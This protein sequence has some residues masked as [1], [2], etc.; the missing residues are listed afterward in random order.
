MWGQKM[1]KDDQENKPVKKE[2]NLPVRRE[3]G[4]AN[5]DLLYG[6]LKKLQY[7]PLLTPEEE[8]DLTR[9]YQ[10][11]KDP[12]IG[13]HL[14]TS[15]LRLVVKI[16][17]EYSTYTSNILDLIQ[18]GNVGLIQAVKHF[19]PF[20]GVRL[21]HYAQYWIRS[22]IIY[23]LL[24][25]HRLVKVGTT[26]AQRKIFFNLRKEQARLLSMGFKPTTKLI[27][28]GLNVPEHTVSEM[29]Q[30][31]DSPDV[32]MDAPRSDDNDTS[33]AGIMP[34]AS[35]TPEQE[36]SENE[37]MDRFREKMDEFGQGLTTYRDRFIWE[38]RLTSDDPVTL[39]TIGEDFGVSR[40]RARQLEER[41]KK[42]F[43]AFVE[44]DLG[45]DFAAA[46][47]ND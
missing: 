26:Q 25:N 12:K 3:K 44:K 29:I 10:E 22:Y 5:V 32:S 46:I 4:G 17:F 28:E 7:Y 15:N 27:A 24:N 43:K 9:Q 42:Q 6:Y 35:P 39:Q 40:E 11:T 13:M 37:I 21:S 18:E 38:K 30:R 20:R 31:M 8:R 16:A 41:L 2:R 36:A 14:V 1:K 47:M 34:S 33:L 45:P 23:Y 19:D